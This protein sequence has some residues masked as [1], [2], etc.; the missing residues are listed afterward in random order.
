MGL[1]VGI[2]FIALSYSGANFASNPQEPSKSEAL[3]TP[4]NS[5]CAKPLSSPFTIYIQEGEETSILYYS[6][7]ALN[8]SKALL[9]MFQFPRATSGRTT[10]RELGLPR[11]E[12]LYD[13]D[14]KIG[15]IIS[16]NGEPHQNMYEMLV[17]PGNGTPLGGSRWFCQN[18]I[19]GEIT[20]RLPSMY[21]KHLEDRSPEEKLYKIVVINSR[22]EMK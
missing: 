5:P 20:L 3:S 18:P 8:P 16:R 19:T 1:R 4:S 13:A 9:R 11:L 7:P 15:A 2:L 12:I 17:Q 6:G 22:E 14:L 10:A 21:Y